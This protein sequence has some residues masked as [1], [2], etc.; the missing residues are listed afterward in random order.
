VDTIFTFVYIFDKPEERCHGFALSGWAK[1]MIHWN[2]MSDAHGA[3]PRWRTWLRGFRASVDTTLDFAPATD[4]EKADLQTTAR[5]PHPGGMTKNC[6]DPARKA[7]MKTLQ[8]WVYA[9]MSEDSHLSYPGLVRRS[10][11]LLRPIEGMPSPDPESYRTMV[12]LSALTVYAALLSE[13]S[14]QL[15]LDHEKGRLRD[16]VWTVLTANP[17]WHLPIAL[18]DARYR[19]LIG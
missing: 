17:D 18:H 3:D 14:C 1:G 10:A 4:A 12:V 15:S 11:I 9:E 2:R 16:D 13:I 6:T 5:W 8:D 19:A 7:F